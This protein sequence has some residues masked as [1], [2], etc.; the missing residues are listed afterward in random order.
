MRS[1]CEPFINNMPFWRHLGPC[2]TWPRHRVVLDLQELLQSDTPCRQVLGVA[3]E[4]EALGHLLHVK[5]S[6][7]LQATSCSERRP[8]GPFTGVEWRNMSRRT[9]GGT[10]LTGI[11]VGPGAMS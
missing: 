6:P 5:T 7:R 11:F 9:A 2:T 4:L 8:M 1:E 10:R 3:L